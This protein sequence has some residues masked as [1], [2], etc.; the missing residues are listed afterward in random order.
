[1]EGQLLAS[2]K[3]DLQLLAEQ[4][5]IMGS[6]SWFASAA[7]DTEP[8]PILGSFAFKDLLCDRQLSLDSFRVIC[9]SLYSTLY[10]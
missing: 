10:C 5:Q 4:T 6:F 9:L 2:L 7:S 8:A 3:V 1:M